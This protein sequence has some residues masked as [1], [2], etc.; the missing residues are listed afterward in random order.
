MGFATEKLGGSTNEA[1]PGQP[2]VNRGR[3]GRSWNLVNFESSLS[4]LFP[5]PQISRN[6]ILL[7]IYLSNSCSVPT[8]MDYLRFSFPLSH[9]NNLDLV[10]SSHDTPSPGWWLPLW[11]F[12]LNLILQLWPL[13]WTL[14]LNIQL[15]L[16]LRLP[17]IWRKVG[18]A[19]FSAVPIWAFQ[20][21]CQDMRLLS[22]KKKTEAQ[23]GGEDR[24][25]TFIIYKS[26]ITTL[27]YS[28]KQ[29]HREAK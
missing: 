17:S 16:F 18:L 12:S 7:T 13:S 25:P 27:P 1:Q 21:A 15:P 28:W 8:T 29:R 2:R 10:F 3:V 6:H 4:S 26:P 9:C 20:S 22:G 5:N 23:M 11:T 14:D 24:S 19:S